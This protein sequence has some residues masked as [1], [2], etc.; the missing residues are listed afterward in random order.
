VLDIAKIESGRLDMA[1]ESFDLRDLVS[2]WEQQMGILA[3]KKQIGFRTSVGE[4][5]PKKL[6]GDPVRITQIATNLLSNA[7]KFTHQGE[8]CLEVREKTEGPIKYWQIVV[9]DTGIG[10]P[11][12]AQNYIFEKFRQVDGSSRRAYG[13]TG[14]GLAI[15]QSLTQTMGGTLTLQ[16]Q[17]GAG[18]T[19]TVTLPQTPVPLPVAAP[20]P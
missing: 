5:L 18:S 14:L 13:G 11:L 8:V 15:S 12:A 6:E 10:I 9:S 7:F 3:Q 16:S 4:T 20:T 17:E 2:Q 19:F 1:I